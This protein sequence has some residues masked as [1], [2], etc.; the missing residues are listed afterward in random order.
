MGERTRLHVSLDDDAG[1]MP[2]SLGWMYLW[3]QTVEDRKSESAV[4]RPFRITH[5]D[6]ELRPHPMHRARHDRLRVKWGR[7]GRQLGQHRP[8]GVHRGSVI[9][10][11]DGP[12]RQE[13]AVLVIT[14]EQ[15]FKRRR[16]CPSDDDEVVR[17]HGL[18]LQPERAALAGHV[19]AL[20][21]FRDHAFEAAL[22]TGFVELDAILLDVVGH[23][24]VAA[25]FH[26][27]A[28]AR[29]PPRQRLPQYWLLIE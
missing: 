10:T 1:P 28:Q 17:L 3:P 20:A 19:R 27:L 5:A 22:E 26:R 14:D 15:R 13:P 23:E 18:D 21:V 2:D 25:G 9:A 29:T 24:D 8:D 11:A 6:D 4:R 12:A 7:V 16:P